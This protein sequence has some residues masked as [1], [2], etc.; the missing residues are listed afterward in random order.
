MKQI[1]DKNLNNQKKLS[2]VK[3]SFAFHLEPGI[4]NLEAG[5]SLLEA[6]VSIFIMLVG[7]TG[8]MTL[9]FNGIVGLGLAKD[10][11]IA[12]NLA[13]E[14]LEVMHNIRDTNWLNSANPAWND[15]DGNGVADVCPFPPGSI[16]EGFVLWDSFIFNKSPEPG[17]LRWNVSD[18]HYNYNS[19][20]ATGKSFSRKITIYNNLDGAIIIQS[21]V[22]WGEVGSCSSGGISINRKYCLTLQERLYNWR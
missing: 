14:G 22:G 6:L 8:S 2:I 10:R 4:Y 5:F 3:K 9:V 11:I 21:T 20:G 12:T 15:W 7:I 17:D 18:N 1:P 16:C 13:Q 19:I